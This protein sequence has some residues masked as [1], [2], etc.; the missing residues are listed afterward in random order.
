MAPSLPRIQLYHQTLHSPASGAPVSL[1]PLLAELPASLH[2]HIVVAIAAIHL[3]DLPAPHLTINDHAASDVRYVELR[4][5]LPRLRAAGITLTAMV[6]GAAAG[7]FTRLDG[8]DWEAYYA[9]LRDFLRAWQLQGADLDVEEPMSLAGA[10]RL[11]RRLR[12]DFGPA[13]VITFAPVAAA[14]QGV[15][16]LSGFDYAAL[17][18]TVGAEIA[19]YNTQFYCGWGSVADGGAGFMAILERGWDPEKVVVGVVTNPDNANGYVELDKLIG[20]LGMLKEFGVGGVMGWE[21][22][23]SLPGGVEAPWEWALHMGGAFGL[24]DE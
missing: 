20:A 17:E 12:A 15:A 18:A 9:L 11:V 1:L 19:W 13:F 10:V 8:A 14:M 16:N 7:T 21:Y 22:F 4:A 23:N 5:S 3:N 6:G 24:F 2:K